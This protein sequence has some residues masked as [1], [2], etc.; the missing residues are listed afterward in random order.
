MIDKLIEEYDA[1]VR[2]TLA[3]L[4]KLAFVEGAHNGKIDSCAYEYIGIITKCPLL[5]HVYKLYYDD[6]TAQ[7]IQVVR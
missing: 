3:H 6:M 7:D 4:A 5:R 1:T 2:R